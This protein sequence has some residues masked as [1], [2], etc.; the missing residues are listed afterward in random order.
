MKIE[1]FNGDNSV[2][3]WSLESKVSSIVE[4]KN[5]FDTDDLRQLLPTLY[6]YSKP[7]IIQ[8]ACISSAPLFNLPDLD[9]NDKNIKLIDVSKKNKTNN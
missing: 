2:S 7:V 3:A 4:Y 8:M 9:F 1:L 6:L 5:E